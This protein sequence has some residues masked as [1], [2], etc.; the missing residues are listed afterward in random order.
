MKNTIVLTPKDARKI[1]RVMKLLEP[2]A[3]EIELSGMLTKVARV[4]RVN[5]KGGK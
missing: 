3:N 1:T 2:L 5:K 4:K